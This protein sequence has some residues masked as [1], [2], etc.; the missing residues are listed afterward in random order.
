VFAWSGAGV[1]LRPE[2]LADV[3]LFEESF[4][5]Y[6]EDTDLSWRGRSRGWRYLTAP[7]AVLRHEHAA[8]SGDGSA[9]KRYHEERNRLAMLVRNAPTGMAL[10]APFR[11]LLAT[12]SYARR[13]VLAP[14]LRGRRP[15]P[16]IVRSRLGALAGFV[17]MLPALLR[18]RRAIRRRA[19]VPDRAVVSWQRDPGA[20]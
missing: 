5:L 13:D 6:Y 14:V 18:A 2:Y 17:A 20:S 10:A 9:L 8:S 1:L 11:H 3:G 4:F 19:T 7:A 12:A 15:D 16:T